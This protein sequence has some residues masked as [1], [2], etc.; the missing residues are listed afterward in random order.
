[1]IMKT[2][3]VNAVLRVV[4]GRGRAAIVPTAITTATIIMGKVGSS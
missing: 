1:M 2:A 4:F 3:H